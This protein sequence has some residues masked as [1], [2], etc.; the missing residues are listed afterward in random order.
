MLIQLRY[1]RLLR[2]QQTFMKSLW[3]SV[4]WGEVSKSFSLRNTGALVNF[5]SP[6]W[7]VVKL[8][9]ACLQAL[10]YPKKCVTQTWEGRYSAKWSGPLWGTCRSSFKVS[11]PR[12]ELRNVRTDW[13]HST[14]EEKKCV[15]KVPF[16][17]CLFDQDSL[18]YLLKSVSIAPLTL[19]GLL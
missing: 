4:S 1:N 10:H 19:L 16:C 7:R 18:S 14:K 15:W 6:G 9:A 5:I 3:G 11:N 13:S 17:S 2:P 8:P 12:P